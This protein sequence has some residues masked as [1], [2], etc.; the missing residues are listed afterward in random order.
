MFTRITSVTRIN[1]YFKMDIPSSTAEHVYESGTELNL[2]PEKL[3]QL[4]D[5]IRDE[6]AKIRENGELPQNILD[7]F[8]SW[9]AERAKI[10]YEA[11]EGRYSAEKD[12]IVESTEKRIAM[13]RNVVQ[14]DV[15]NTI[16]A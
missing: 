7:A 9:E 14:N 12:S 10:G 1:T 11:A 4:R 8:N 13:L 15:N 2:S 3:S 16:E 6:F 5:T